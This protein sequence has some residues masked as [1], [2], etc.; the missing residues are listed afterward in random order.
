MGRIIEGIYHPS[1]TEILVATQLGPDY[2]RVPVP[3]ATMD[4]ARLRGQAVHAA[5]QYDLEGTLDEGTIHS[6]VRG[7]LEAARRFCRESGFKAELVEPEWIHPTWHYLGHPDVVGHLN[8][9][10]VGIDW[11]HG[12]FDPFAT[13]LQLAGYDLLWAVNGADEPLDHWLVVELHPDGTYRTVRVGVRI[14][15]QT[16]LAALVVFR[17]LQ[18]KGRS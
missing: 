16:F 7:G 3:A 14:H 8:G 9:A 1:C 11:K 13:P 6:D 18:E 12:S 2:S 15:H 4:R 5:I 17:A 10:G